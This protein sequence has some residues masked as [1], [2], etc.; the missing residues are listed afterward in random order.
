M[1]A[2]DIIKSTIESLTKA[3]S[4]KRALAKDMKRH[5]EAFEADADAL[6]A[7]ADELNAMLT[8]EAPKPVAKAKAKT[9]K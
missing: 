3:A 5:A 2:A 4:D 8:T 9:S 6:M 1:S 7:D